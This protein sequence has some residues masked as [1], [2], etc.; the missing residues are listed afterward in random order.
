MCWLMV[1]TNIFL[2]SWFIKMTNNLVVGNNVY[3][4]Y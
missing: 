3:Y 1:I 2:F 4:L